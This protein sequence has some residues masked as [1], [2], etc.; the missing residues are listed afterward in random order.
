MIPT[1]C[2]ILG[3]VFVGFEISGFHEPGIR[4]LF[5][6]FWLIGAHFQTQ[7]AHQEYLRRA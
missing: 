1:L 3:P 5:A 6:P 7:E 2:V 4:N